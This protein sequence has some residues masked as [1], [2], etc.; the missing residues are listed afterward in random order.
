MAAWLVFVRGHSHAVVDPLADR[1]SGLW[2]EHGTEGIVDA[3]FSDAGLLPA[4]SGLD[5]LS[6]RELMRM[7][8]DQTSA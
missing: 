6:R 4:T 1:L 8:H 7:V 5:G 3:V 2:N